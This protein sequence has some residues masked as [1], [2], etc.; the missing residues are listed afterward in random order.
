MPY[1]APTLKW[2][3]GGGGDSNATTD[4]YAV[5]VAVGDLVVVSCTTSDSLRNWTNIYGGSVPT[6]YAGPALA[7]AIDWG[8]AGIWAGWANTAGTHNVSMDFTGG[9]AGANYQQMRIW[10]W[11][12]SD[13]YG[14]GASERKTGNADV[15]LPINRAVS[16]AV[17]AAIDWDVTA[18]Q[19]T[20]QQQGGPGYLDSYFAGGAAR[21]WSGHNIPMNSNGSFWVGNYGTGGKVTVVAQEILGRWYDNTPP[22]VPTG[23]TAVAN[24]Q[25]SITISWNASTDTDAVAAS[26]LASYRVR[27]NGVDLAGATALTGTSFT[28]TTAKLTDTYT[29]SAVDNNG[30]RSG[31]SAVASTSATKMKLGSTALTVMKYGT[32]NVSRLYMGTTRV[33]P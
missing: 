23:V 21:Y 17:W 25:T 10:V 18:T 6:W 24:S 28:D 1:V 7:D 19:G 20:T 12:G 29:V 8:D 32:A 30:N 22:S 4:T 15:Y 27:R 9:N 33:F 2:V 3:G 14:G 13:G 16:G 26:G 31:E 5:P 11:G